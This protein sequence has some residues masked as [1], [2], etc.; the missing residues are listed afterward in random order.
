M[1]GKALFRLLQKKEG[2]RKGNFAIIQQE[3]LIAMLAKLGY[4][5]FINGKR[6][7]GDERDAEFERYCYNI[8]C[9]NR[10]MAHT[11]YTGILALQYWRNVKITF[12]LSF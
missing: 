9:Q 2:S 6:V 1:Y 8:P 7:P 11:V 5:I 12:C 3:N 4:A 10:Q